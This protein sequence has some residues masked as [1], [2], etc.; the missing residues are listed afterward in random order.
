MNGG[1]GKVDTRRYW[2][3]VREIERGLPEPTWIVS[4]SG[5]QQ[6]AE[7]DRL[8]AARALAGSTHR[9]ATDSEIAAY[10]DDQVAKARFVRAEA[11]RK[12]GIATGR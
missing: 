2:A 6:L 8:T 4:L 9:L 1:G 5:R 12:A 10:H 3:S 11:Y 7:C